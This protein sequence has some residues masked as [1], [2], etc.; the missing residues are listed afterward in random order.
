MAR[1]REYAVTVYSADTLSAVCEM[2]AH[3]TGDLLVA[4][5][6]KD[7]TAAIVTPANWYLSVASASTGAYGGV[8]TRRAQSSAE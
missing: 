1:V 3:Q 8:Y 4:F 6:G 7:G 2:P 5:A